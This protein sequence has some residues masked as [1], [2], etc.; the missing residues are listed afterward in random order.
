MGR[1]HR[2]R[3][4][5]RAHDD[6]EPGRAHPKKPSRTAAA[7][8]VGHAIGIL[9][10]DVV[11]GGREPVALQPRRRR[12]R[13]RLGA[14]LGRR[15]RLVPGIGQHE[16][17]GRLERGVARRRAMLPERAHDLEVPVHGRGGAR[18]G[19][20]RARGS[21]RARRRWPGPAA[22]GSTRACAPRSSAGVRWSRRGGV[23]AAR[24]ASHEG[25]QS[26]SS[27]IPPSTQ[28]IPRTAAGC[29]QPSSST[30]LPPHDCPATTGR[31][32]PRASIT[33]RRSPT[34]VSMS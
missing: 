15:A 21:R 26:A 29:R 27:M 28:M 4:L 25:N 6:E 19:R 16:Q 20:P 7:K 3:G 12:P 31:E 5:A 30:T 13:L 17:R 32:S 33:A 9:R 11:V 18:P 23:S 24:Q 1:H 14:A 34:A 22:P 2:G 8:S 10:V